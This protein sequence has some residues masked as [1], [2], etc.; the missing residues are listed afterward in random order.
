MQHTRAWIGVGAPCVR[1]VDPSRDVGKFSLHSGP[2]LISSILAM[3]VAYVFLVRGRR[4]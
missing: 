4:S 3:C 2:P 1:R